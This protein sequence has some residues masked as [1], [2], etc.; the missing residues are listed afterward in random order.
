MLYGL[1][2]QIVGVLIAHWLMGVF[3]EAYEEHYGKDISAGAE[4]EV[5]KEV[6]TVESA[7]CGG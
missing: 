4:A 6:E 7:I 1:A 2:R 5:E 3:K